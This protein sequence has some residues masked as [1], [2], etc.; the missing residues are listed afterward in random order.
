MTPKGITKN[1]AKYFGKI[2]AVF[3]NIQKTCVKI[4]LN[5]SEEM[6]GMKID[7]FGLLD[8]KTHLVGIRLTH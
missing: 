2:N 5:I 1:S 8:T 3:L 4:D 7:L 6:K